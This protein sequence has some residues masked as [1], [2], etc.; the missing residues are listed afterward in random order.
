MRLRIGC[1]MW[2]PFAEASPLRKHTPRVSS[3]NFPLKRP[4]V[5]P[6]ADCA[7]GA[8]GEGGHDGAALL[9]TQHLDLRRWRRRWTA[10]RRQRHISAAWSRRT[11]AMAFAAQ[12]LDLDLGRRWQ[13]HV[14][15]Q[16]DQQQCRSWVA[17]STDVG[18]VQLQRW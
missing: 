8:V 11:G 7:A 5:A 15:W 12:H 16:R 17:G 14:A 18:H 2:Q 10:W 4:R 1:Q 3:S 9:A 6:C 13:Q